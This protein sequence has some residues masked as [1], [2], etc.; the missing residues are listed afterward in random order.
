VRPAASEPSAD[1]SLT[2]AARGLGLV[3][4]AGASVWLLF[5]VALPTF[6]TAGFPPSQ[7]ALRGPY[8]GAVDLLHGDNPY[9]G[10]TE[11]ASDRLARE[12]GVERM[13][14]L[15]APPVLLLYAPLTA[16]GFTGA[17]VVAVIANLACV[18]LVAWL[19]VR[20]LRAPPA[21]VPLALL[22]VAAFQEVQRTLILGQINLLL[23]LALALAM[24]WADEE[25][26][27]AAGVLLGLATLVKPIPAALVLA[28]ALRRQW[29]GAAAWL[30]TLLL[31]GSL[32]VMLF[33]IERN[34]D[35]LAATR[36]VASQPNAG[37]GNQSLRALQLRASGDESPPALARD[38]TWWLSAL[39]LVGAS[40]AVVV[41]R[42]AAPLRLGLALFLAAGLLASPRSLDNYSIWL[43]PALALAFWES[44]RAGRWWLVVLSGAAYHLS[45]IPASVSREESLLPR[46]LP[47]WVFANS[48]VLGLLLTWLLLMALHLAPSQQPEA[49]G[50][51]QSSQ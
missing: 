36:A 2:R 43:L 20:L 15:Y 26:P 19:L 17:K 40:A 27:V 23:L 34:R 18:P 44:A 51:Q 33:G 5:G 50:Q 45:S 13:L 25:R 11:R 16:L 42:P 10:G 46:V 22:A 28:F 49:Q 8:F 29:R 21:A 35:F 41:L 24:L 6:R 4:A 9:R 39:A 37:P 31:C 48:Q 14:T 1:A 38:T 30:A 32:S 3:L 12:L 7:H 47:A